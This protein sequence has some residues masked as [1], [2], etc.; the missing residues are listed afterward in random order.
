MIEMAY[1]S[2]KIFMVSAINLIQSPIG[3]LKLPVEMAG[4]ATDSIPSSKTICIIP[5]TTLFI[6]SSSLELSAFDWYLGPT[7]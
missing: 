1:L 4:I 7:A 6:C 3:N 2:M 5:L